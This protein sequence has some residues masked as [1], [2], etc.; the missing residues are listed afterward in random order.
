MSA[1]KWDGVWDEGRNLYG[2]KLFAHITRRLGR[3][4][5]PE[6]IDGFTDWV[7]SE[8]YRLEQSLTGTHEAR[9]LLVDEYLDESED[10]RRVAA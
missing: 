2:K 7:E 9:C 10:A 5:A 3:L 6:E 8:S 4:P 1:V